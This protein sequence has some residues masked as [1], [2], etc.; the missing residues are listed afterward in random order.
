MDGYVTVVPANKRKR[1]EPVRDQS[2]WSSFTFCKARIGRSP[3]LRTE[4]D[5]RHE[6]GELTTPSVRLANHKLASKRARAS[7]GAGSGAL[8]PAAI[9]AWVDS[10]DDSVWIEIMRHLDVTTLLAFACLSRRFAEL[11]TS[12]S[13]WRFHVARLTQGERLHVGLVD[14]HSCAINILTARCCARMHYVY[15]DAYWKNK[16]VDR[17]LTHVCTY[18]AKTVYRGTLYAMLVW[19]QRR[20]RGVQANS[21]LVFDTPQNRVMG[22]AQRYELLRRTLQAAS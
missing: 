19:N 14:P 9:A 16:N 22:F 11:A 2:P 15:P 12:N 1:T 20:S 17:L 4:I 21:S 10:L 3:P 8:R 6:A 18:N 13:L 5:K 7:L